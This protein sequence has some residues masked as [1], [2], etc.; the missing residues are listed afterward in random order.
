MLGRV[1][2]ELQSLIAWSKLLRRINSNF[3]PKILY[4]FSVSV[5]KLAQ[6][7]AYGVEE[8]VFH[9]FDIY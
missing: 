7:Q 5:S 2:V 6:T 3:I 1:V 8:F 9:L 4:L